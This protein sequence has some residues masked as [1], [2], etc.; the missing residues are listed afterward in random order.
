[1]GWVIEYFEQEGMTQP[2]E[3]FEDAL[4]RTHPR[5]AAKLARIAVEL[6]GQ[7]HRLGGGLVEPCRGYTGLWELRAIHNQWLGREFFGF[8]GARVV[9]LHGYVKRGGQRAS[10]RDLAIAFGYWTEYLRTHKVS[11]AAEEKG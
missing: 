10:A 11:P 7:G 4:D 2:A 8:D 6:Q 3:L 5:L 9:L 1:M